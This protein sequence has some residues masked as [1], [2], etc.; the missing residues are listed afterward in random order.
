MAKFKYKFESVKKIKETIEKKVQK[1]I[2]IIDLEIDEVN[3]SFR[4]ILAEKEAFRK[5]IEVKTCLK[6]S[7]LQF[8]D[9]AEYLLDLQLEKLLDELNQLRLKRE[10]KIL[11]LA[12]KTKEHKIFEYL[13]ERHYEEYLMD[14][15][16]IE[17]KEIDEIATK[18]FAK[19]A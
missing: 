1:E 18:K 10:N 3:N 11:E 12:Q 19:E 4:D 16:Q 5:S 7:E 2:S 15:N 14:Q 17:Q 13:E 8:H 6:A 9:D